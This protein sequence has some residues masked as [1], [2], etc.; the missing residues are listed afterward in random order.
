M[1]TPPFIDEPR[2]VRR[3]RVAKI[4]IVRDNQSPPRYTAQEMI[5]ILLRMG[6]EFKKIDRAHVNN[7]HQP[8]NYFADLASSLM[9]ILK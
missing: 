8:L 7:I 9:R 5:T 2:N 4:Q 3:T 6:Y 1:Y